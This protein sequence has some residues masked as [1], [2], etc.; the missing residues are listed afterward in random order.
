MPRGTLILPYDR[1]VPEEMDLDMFERAWRD[2]SENVHILRAGNMWRAVELP[3]K[4][5]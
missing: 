3:R 5:G 4:I 1:L 2:K